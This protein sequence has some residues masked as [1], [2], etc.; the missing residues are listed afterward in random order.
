MTG[1]ERRYALDPATVLVDDLLIGGTPLT[2]MRL[3]EAGRSTVERIRSGE[4]VGS[5]R[6]LERLLAV[7]IAT[8]IPGSPSTT[9]WRTA[10][11]TPSLGP[12][13]H[14]PAPGTVL[15]DDGSQPPISG[16][17]LRSDRNLGPAA[18]RNLG[19]RSV[20]ADRPDTDL[21]VFVDADVDTGAEDWWVPLLEH[22][23]DPN[24]GLVAPRVRAPSRGSRLTDR[25]ERAA[26]ALDLGPTTGRVAPG[27]RIA[28]VPSAAVIAR[29]SALLDVDGYDESLRTGEDVDL[30]WRL[31]Q[32]GWV[33]IYDATVTVEHSARAAI[34]GWLA[35][36]FGYGRSATSLAER[37]GTAL[38]PWRTSPW[39][40]TI[41]CALGFS[42]GRARPRALL[43]A[44]AIFA[45][46]TTAAFGLTRRVPGLPSGIATRIIGRGL[47]RSTIAAL[48]AIRRAWWPLLIPALPLSRVVRRMTVMSILAAR[49]PARLAADLA[50]GAGTVRGAIDR[51]ST[52]AL[53][54][55]VS[56]GRVMSRSAD[57]GATKT[58]GDSTTVG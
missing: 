28:Y 30:V 46:T 12:P 31:H 22:F 57:G 51:R 17:S 6:L 4:T 56:A 48:A 38:A 29:A 20:L 3:T 37:H 53:L 52:R 44:L 13:L 26:P 2:L 1:P 50:Y 55:V 27:T 9:S 45:T 35:Q 18:A 41:V 10:V 14:P 7:G 34:G 43:P 19:W 39:G 5:G 11:V 25:A 47:V 40:V 8:P 23:D 58:A 16:A 32:Q 42:L 49:H 36:R 15:V 33:T 21:I 24:V 54:P